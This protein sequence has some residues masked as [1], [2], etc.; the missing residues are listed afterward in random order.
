M[1]AVFITFLLSLN[2]LSLSEE[3][4][5]KEKMLI[6]RLDTK[7]L[8]P[9]SKK[10]P[11]QELYSSLYPILDQLLYVN[12][13]YDLGA[14]LLQSFRWDHR[15]K[16]YVLKLRKGLRF[17]NGRAVTAKDLEFSILRGLLTPKRSYFSAFFNNIEGVEKLGVINKFKSGIVSGVKIVGDDEVEIKI[18]KP[19]PSFLH[20]L[21]RPTFSLV[22]IEELNDSDY[23]VWK[24]WPIGAGGY[25]VHNMNDT[26]NMIL[27]KISKASY[28]PDLIKIDFS[29]DEQFPDIIVNKAKD[30]DKYS[31]AYSKKSTF[32]T[33]IFFNFNNYLGRSLDF[34]KA[35]HHAINRAE[36]VK[37]APELKENQQFLASHLWG[38]INVS[39]DYSLEK[40]KSLFNKINDFK[41]QSSIKIPVYGRV[42]DDL[43]ILE[44]QLIQAGLPIKFFASREKNFSK[45]DNK[46]PF[47]VASPGADVADSI[48][49]F[50]LMRGENSPYWP[51][52]PK[53][54]KKYEKLIDLA[55]NTSSLD[56]KVLATKELSQ[57]FYDNKISV[58]LFEGRTFISFNKDR[59][60]SLGLQNGGLTF[61]LNRVEIRED[62]K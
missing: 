14:G 48:V 62:I 29:E 37:V 49:L 61:Y 17:H 19:N 34:R 4:I 22:P 25:R 58:P 55:K 60:K 38:R 50:E 11:V 12:E 45:I 10:A 57:Y 35:V 33:G 20:S 16:S 41:N 23:E 51:H 31:I 43:K 21:A 6:V 32:V 59:I 30:G 53:N 56:K 3:K 39:N 13:N 8:A 40:A 47:R 7:G 9:F 2:S 15:K 5:M 18:K 36:I 26:K 54:D 52:F 24:K 42:T 44:K 46:T 1:K 27:K 28:G